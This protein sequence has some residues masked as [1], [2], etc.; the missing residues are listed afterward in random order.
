MARD[1]RYYTEEGQ[2]LGNGKIPGH[3]GQECKKLIIPNYVWKQRK[4]SMFVKSSV[5]IGF[6]KKIIAKVFGG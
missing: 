4:V 2:W 6:S 5:A 1:D 3:T